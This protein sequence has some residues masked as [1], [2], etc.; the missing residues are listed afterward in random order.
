MLERH[1]SLTEVRICTLLFCIIMIAK[2]YIG[3]L[4]AEVL[5]KAAVAN[6]KMKALF[7]CTNM[8]C[9][10]ILGNPQ[11]SEAKRTEIRAIKR[12][13]LELYPYSMSNPPLVTNCY[14]SGRCC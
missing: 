1:A 13:N 3:D 5:A 7:L 11:V 12:P 6:Q 2:N 9:E 14:L 10:P 8:L 4:G